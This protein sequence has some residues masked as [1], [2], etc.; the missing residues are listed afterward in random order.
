MKNIILTDV[1]KDGYTM[2][3]RV[4]EDGTVH[5]YV[6]AYGY[7]SEEIGWAS[8]NYFGKNLSGAYKFYQLR[9]NGIVVIEETEY[10]HDGYVSEEQE[11]EERFFA[12]E[13]Y[14]PLDDTDFF[15]E[16]GIPYL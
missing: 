6:V 3:A 7:V 14:V 5:E 16:N 4:K 9:E 1:N 2:L 12:S 13:E 15:D 8:G 10:E 11:I